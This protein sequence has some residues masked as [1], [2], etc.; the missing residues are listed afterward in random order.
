MLREKDN[1]KP[2]PV[3]EFLKKEHTEEIKVACEKHGVGWSIA[4]CAYVCPAVLG[5]AETAPDG[6]CAIRLRLLKFF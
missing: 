6:R 3:G 4:L 2:C 5:V 1:G